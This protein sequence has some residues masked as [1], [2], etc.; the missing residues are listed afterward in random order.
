VNE[1]RWRIL[2]IMTFRC[3]SQTRYIAQCILVKQAFIHDFI[4]PM[5][6]CYFSV[7]ALSKL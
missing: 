2:K 5:W 6:K 7:V 4:N 3:R 1:K